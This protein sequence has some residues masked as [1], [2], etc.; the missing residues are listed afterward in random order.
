MLEAEQITNSKSKEDAFIELTT[1]INSCEDRYLNDFIGGLNWIRHEPVL[2]WI[3]ENSNRISNVTQSWG[4]LAAS[5]NFSWERAKKWLELGRPLSL[6][7]LDGL[8]FCTSTGERLNQSPWMREIRPTLTDNPQLDEVA[9]KL[10]EFIKTDSVPRTKNLVNRI[11]QNI[12]E[13][14]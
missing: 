10:Q 7:A 13:T 9:N 12:F 11:I 1:K 8:M 3:E 5:S 2:D 6:I 4:H 14:E